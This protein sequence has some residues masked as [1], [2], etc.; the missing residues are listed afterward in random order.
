MITTANQMY[1]AVLHELRDENTASLTP[2]EF[3]YFIN[4]AMLQW[5]QTRFFALEESQKHIDDLER[6]L[7]RTNGVSDSPVPLLNRGAAKAGEEFFAF[8][9]NAVTF[10]DK[11]FLI[12]VQFQMAAHPCYNNT[13]PVLSAR[14]KKTDTI[15]NG[16]A[17]D[18][19]TDN[20]LFYYQSG[21]KIFRYDSGSS[22]SVAQKAIVTYIRMPRE[23]KVDEETG[24]SISNPEFDPR[25]NLEIVK[26]A[27]RSYLETTESPRQNSF[28]AE[29]AGVN[30][31]LGPLQKR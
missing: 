3:N 12:S 22:V 5:L 17:Y 16:N 13:M 29:Q 21:G 30:N 1:I 9:A 24:E 25:V 27:V 6:L 7:V 8:P 28:A 23:I 4:A 10:S 18:R 14:I 26:W 11:A 15:S 2:S 20:R 31:L 19:P